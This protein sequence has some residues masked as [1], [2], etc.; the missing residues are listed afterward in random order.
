MIA[1]LHRSLERRGAYRSGV[2]DGEAPRRAAA[3]LQEALGP[4]A[5]RAPRPDGD[6]SVKESTLSRRLSEFVG[7]AL[8]ALALIW[9]ISLVTHDADGSG[10]VLYDRRGSRTGEFRRPRRRVSLRAVVPVVRL[11]GVSHSRGDRR[12]WLA[13]LLVPD[14]RCGLYEADRRRAALRLHQRIPEPGL[15]QHGSGRQDRSTP[16]DR[17]AARSASSVGLSESHRLAHRPADDDDAGG[18]SVDAVLVR[19]DVRHGNGELAGL[20]GT[21]H[22]LAPRVD[23]AQAQGHG[24][25]RSHRQAR[26]ASC[27]CGEARS[28]A[29]SRERRATRAARQIDRARSR[30]TVATA[31][32]ARRRAED[33]RKPHRSRCP[34]RPRRLR[35]GGRERSRCRRHRCSTR[36]RPNA[37]STSA[38]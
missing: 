31:V 22:R 24:A 9:L 32:A 25:A 3:I 30:V 29:C 7:V 15:R 36:Q 2:D 26:Q 35:S 4:T 6:L 16:A 23:R 17:S 12:R 37:R 20:L 33:G 5:A 27:R 8:F 38:S 1:R 21:R 34:R 28:R 19:T 13:L 11:R 14:A 10:V 18:H